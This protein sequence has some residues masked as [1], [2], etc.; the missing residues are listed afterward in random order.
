LV[1]GIGRGKGA[2]SAAAV[3]PTQADDMEDV[4]EMATNNEN[5]SQ[6]LEALKQA[7]REGLEDEEMD[8]RK[9]ELLDTYQ[10]FA[11]RLAKAARV[12]A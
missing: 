12:S 11:P 4:I 10:A 9:R 5:R 3:A 1:K 2:A 8:T 6:F 7:D